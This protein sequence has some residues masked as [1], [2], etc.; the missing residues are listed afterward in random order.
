MGHQIKERSKPW[1]LSYVILDITQVSAKLLKGKSIFTTS[2]FQPYI[3]LCFSG[4][5]PIN[6]RS[7]LRHL[8]IP[9]VI[10]NSYSYLH[11]S[12]T[13]VILPH[14]LPRVVFLFVFFFLFVVDFCFVFCFVLVWFVF[15]G[16][17]SFRGWEGV[18]SNCNV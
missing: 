17:I 13:L 5:R 8:S 10:P 7:I 6:I 18:S 15:L 12:P 1:W 3:N 14:H 2:I 11:S 16:G 9:L 4:S